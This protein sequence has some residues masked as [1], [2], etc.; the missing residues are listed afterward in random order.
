MKIATISD[1]LARPLWMA[2]GMCGRAGIILRVGVVSGLT[3]GWPGPLGIHLSI[4]D[5]REIAPNMECE[6]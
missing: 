3:R 1:R 6:E 5:L 4:N 2:S